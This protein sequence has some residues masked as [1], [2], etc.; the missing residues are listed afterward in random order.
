MTMTTDR[1]TGP[2]DGGDRRPVDESI[3]SF[4]HVADQ[5]RL[6][7]RRLLGLTMVAA[8]LAVVGGQLG[9]FSADLFDDV[10]QART[11]VEYRGNSWTETEDVAVRSRSLTGPI[12]ARYGVDIKD[13][14]EDMEAGLVGG[15]Q[16][17]RIEYFDEDADK[18][19][20]IVSDLAEAYIADAS[21][22]PPE[23]RETLLES[24]LVELENEL[25]SAQ[26]DLEAGAPE[27]GAPLSA[28]Q[29]DLQSEIAS[30]R[31]RIGVLELR[32]LDGQLALED[33][34]A[35]GLPRY[36]T[37]PFV[38]QEPYFPR[39]LRLA[40]FGA[41]IGLMLGLIPLLWNLYRP[42]STPAS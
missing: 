31:A 17:L 5:P 22:R 18:A 9:Y 16:I 42:G 14:E 41:A 1:P 35:Q 38:F 8:V 11:E 39:P 30:L 10:W 12:A 34:E 32:I 4:Q 27:P 3:V 20:A 2:Q 37:R 33:L 26:N 19:Q 23:S 24:Q 13:F 15:T 36:V 7:A 40:V 28:E 25:T 29:Q 6:P 21:E